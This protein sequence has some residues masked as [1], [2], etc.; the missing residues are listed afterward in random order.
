MRRRLTSLTLATALALVAA[1]CG[2]RDDSDGAATT[3][4]QGSSTTAAGATETN[5]AADP[6]EA[7]E[8]G[9]TADEIHI[10]VVADVDTPISPGL[11]RPIVA[12][13]EAW[14]ES[15]NARGGLAGRQVVITFYDS[16]LNPDEAVNAFTQACQGEFATVGS[17]AFVLLN[18]EPIQTCIDQAGNAIG[19]PDLAAVAISAGQAQSPTTYGLTLAGQDFSASE[20]TWEVPQYGWD[21]IE[22]TL[23]EGVT[24]KMIGIDPGVPGIGPLFR[25]FNAA[26]VARGWEDAGVISYPDA[27]T[28]AEATPIVQR[29][30]DEGINV[31]S[32]AS[33]GIA[34]LMA[35]A[36]VQGIDMDSIFWMCTGQ[37]L[38]PSF[39]STNAE[40]I[41][42]LHV[43]S[44]LAPYDETDIEGVGMYRERVA[45]EDVS[46]NGLTAFG[47]GLIFEE[48]VNQVVADSGVN[49]LTR[50]ALLDAL[51]SGP[52]VA[53]KGVL[54]DSTIPGKLNTCW[55]TSQA[56]TGA[57]VLV[58]PPDPGTFNCDPDV[59]VRVTG[60]FSG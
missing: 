40:A 2:G 3:A 29:I 43:S 47:A 21:Y 4:D 5:A 15:V 27:A 28:Q 12:A 31:V 56:R 18:P 16:K 6:T 7:T 53:S 24:P 50:Q 30:K 49:G 44:P 52:S 51:A 34:K 46:A 57:F 45:D 9:I 33:I 59:I 32:S 58:D 54:D 41:E 26:G 35:E 17:G 25:A 20:E 36:R 37:C 55:T 22:Q 48:L 42:G 10:G 14:G 39:A 11:S 13:V 19:L 60:S 38:T 23:G 8:V 1:G